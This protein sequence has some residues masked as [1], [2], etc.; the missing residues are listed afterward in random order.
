VYTLCSRYR[1]SGFREFTPFNKDMFQH[2][3]G[4]L[5]EIFAKKCKNPQ[6]RPALA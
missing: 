6:K 3:G 2:F 5:E 1:F 4:T